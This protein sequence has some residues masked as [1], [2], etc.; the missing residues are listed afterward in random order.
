MRLGLG[1][2]IDAGGILLKLLEQFSGA[3]AAYSLYDLSLDTTN[4]VRLRR[5]S[6]NAE[7]DFT[8]AEVSDGT[9]TDWVNGYSDTLPLDT[10]SAA[11]AYS[12][13][14]V[15]TAYTG[16]VVRVR[17]SSDNAE[18][19]FNP[20]EIN[21]GT[22]TTWTGANDGFV[23]TWYDQSG[24]SLHATQSTAANQPK[25]VSAGSVIL[26]NG[27]SAIDFDGSDDYLATSSGYPTGTSAS[28]FYIASSTA[29]NQ[30]VIDTRGTG[31]AG[32]VQGWHHKYTN[33]ADV[34]AIDDGTASIQLSNIIRTGQNLVSVLFSQTQ[35]DEYTNSLLEDSLTGS[36]GSFDSGNPLY[37]GANANGANTQIFDGTL[38]EIVLY[39]SDQSSNRTTIE[40]NINQ[41]YD[42]YNADGFVVT[43]YDQ[44]ANTNDATQSTA[45]HQAKIVSGGSLITSNGY[46][47]I[48]YD[49]TND[50][51]GISSL[52]ATGTMLMAGADGSAFYEVDINGAYNLLADAN[53][54]DHPLNETI[55]IIW[56]R[57]L[58]A[59]EKTAIESIVNYTDWDF[60]DI[61]SFERYWRDRSE[62]TSF[63]LIDTSSGTNFSEAWRDCL[64]LTIIPKNMFDSCAATNFT[65]AFINTNLTS[66]SIE[67]IVVSIDTAGQ[68]NGTLDI[69]GG[70]NATTATAQTAI[71]NLRGK[72]WTVT[73]PDGY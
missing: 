55:R 45:S 14:Y 21:D 40:G 29:T 39:N 17:R 8:A 9:M 42:I 12:L 22:L 3:V 2:G 66:Q 34:T 62:F 26:E 48:Q 49:G 69:T 6:D 57:T 19:D 27:Q 65:N 24:N 31:D 53:F 7:S 50:N 68:S 20:T 23:T 59:S 4:I 33:A 41:Y 13:R 25:I 56:N 58:S 46:N 73:V 72:G 1:L 44:S 10:A 63:P 32:T 61:T 16:D 11:A 18:A 47:V 71:D 54:T 30:R 15:R 67:N 52:T 37:I 5:S 36:I 38:Q 43:W 28:H 51:L 35:V 60:S 70:G 64:S